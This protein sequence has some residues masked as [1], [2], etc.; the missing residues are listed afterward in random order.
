[1]NKFISSSASKLF[2]ICAIASVSSFLNFATFAKSNKVSVSEKKF[3]EKYFPYSEFFNCKPKGWFSGYSSDTTFAF[4]DPYIIIIDYEPNFSKKTYDINEV[5]HIVKVANRTKGQL[6]GQLYYPSIKAINDEVGSS[7]NPIRGSFL[8]SSDGWFGDIEI[9]VNEHGDTS[10]TK[11]G[12]VLEIY[13][14]LR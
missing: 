7:V 11:F 6:L 5:F 12:C 2:I 9:T 13:E 10:T 3:V 14:M 1:M 4:A 8:M